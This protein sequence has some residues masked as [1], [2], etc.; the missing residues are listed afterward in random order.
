M[1]RRVDLLRTDVSEERSAYMTPRSSETYV[2]QE[3][4]GVISQKMAFFRIN[5]LKTSNVTKLVLL[6]QP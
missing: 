2:L 4:H 6:M 1:L 3:S 5:A